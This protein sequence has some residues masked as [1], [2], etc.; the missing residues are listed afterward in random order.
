MKIKI[1]EYLITSQ[2]VKTKPLGN[3][4]TLRVLFVVARVGMGE[5]SLPKTR[6]SGCCQTA[7]TA[8]STRIVYKH[9]DGTKK[10]EWKAR[11]PAKKVLTNRKLYLFLILLLPQL[12]N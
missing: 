11:P 9:R 3:F 1:T 8:G 5:S 2:Y 6:P 12:K 4:V 10:V 7:A